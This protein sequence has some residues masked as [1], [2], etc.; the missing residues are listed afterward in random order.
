[1]QS[2]NFK[3]GYALGKGGAAKNY[4]NK[5]ININEGYFTAIAITKNKK[6]NLKNLPI[7]NS[8]IKV[9]KGSSAKVEMKKLLERPFKEELFK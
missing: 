7:L 1:M 8:L 6:I 4:I 9:I 2:R 5:N 3:L